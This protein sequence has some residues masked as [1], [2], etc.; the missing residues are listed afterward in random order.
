VCC[1]KD[2]LIVPGTKAS[3]NPSLVAPRRDWLS[4]GRQI[5]V[6]CVAKTHL[7]KWRAHFWDRGQSFASLGRKEQVN[8]VETSAT[9]NTRPTGRVSTSQLPTGEAASEENLPK[10]GKIIDDQFVI[11]CGNVR[12]PGSSR[13]LGR[14]V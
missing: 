5:S 14:R 6:A 9:N 12:T 1:R 10:N 7:G 11:L 3:P 2:A 4:S 13:R 8:V